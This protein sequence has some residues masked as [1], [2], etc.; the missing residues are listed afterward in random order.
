MLGDF[1]LDMS[2][3]SFKEY[4]NNA[5]R[6]ESDE[7]IYL[8]KQKD[9]LDITNIVTDGYPFY[10]GE[11][12]FCTTLDYKQGAPTIFRLTGRYATAKVIVNGSLVSSLILTEYVE[13]KEFL[14]VGK[15]TVAITLC[16]NYRNLLGPHYKQAAELIPVSPKWFSFEKKW[17]GACCNEFKSHYSFVRFGIDI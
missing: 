5:F 2:K 13:L 1:T 15:N 17:N 8:V 12:T 3:D 16:N 4:P 10:C 9:C 11:V 7:S 14:E 6:Y